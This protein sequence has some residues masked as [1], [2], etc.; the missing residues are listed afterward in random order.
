MQ[1]QFKVITE[2]FENYY[3][4]NTGKVFSKFKNDF[5]KLNV[6]KKGYVVV[7]FYRGNGTNDYRTFNLHTLVYKYFSGLKYDPTLDIDHISNNKNDNSI[8][9][10]QQITHQQNIQKSWDFKKQSTKSC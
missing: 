2:G 3:I 10:L 4:T 8:S 7:K 1:E 9:N 6:N 5:L